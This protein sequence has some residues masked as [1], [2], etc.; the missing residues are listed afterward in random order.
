MNVLSIDL[1]VHA[2]DERWGKPLSDF[3][4]ALAA[5]GV[6]L[7]GLLDHVEFYL[8]GTGGFMKEYLQQQKAKGTTAY[9]EDLDGLRALYRDLD[10]LA[11]PEG[12]R[13]L[14]GLEVKDADATP[15]EYLALPDYLCFCFGEVHDPPG[16]PFGK[17]AAAM[18]RKVGKAFAPS[19]KPGIVNHAFRNR[20]WAY[21][22]LLAKGGAP[23]PEAF[24][25]ADDI[26]RMVEA[27]KEGAL[28]IEVNLSD[29]G[30]YAKPEQRPMLDLLLHATTQLVRCGADLSIGSDSHSPPAPA[31]S[32]AVI[33]VIE[34]AGVNEN[35]L[36]HILG[37]I[38]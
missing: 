32:P 36:R 26:A 4:R 37:R 5:R 12:L 15:A 24:I 22:D 27:A 13:I 14:K 35:H 30:S 10:A 29:L 6:V 7:A 16:E 11:R 2:G 1:H 25:T 3:T 31:L 23:P 20:A 28:A 9:P 19:G 17:R 34:K 18:I 33:E 38:G 8:P 21:R